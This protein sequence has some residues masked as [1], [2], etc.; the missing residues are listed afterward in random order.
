MYVFPSQW[1]N[2][3]INIKKKKVGNRGVPT[4][5]Q[6]DRWCLGS[7]GTTWQ[8]RSP[9]WHRR[10]K[11]RGCHSFSLGC[12]WGSDHP[13]PGN[14]MCWGGVAKKKTKN[15]C[16]LSSPPWKLWLRGQLSRGRR[17]GSGGGSLLLLC[18][19]DRDPP[20]GGDP[21]PPLQSAL[22]GA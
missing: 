16:P 17:K 21:L 11:T 20:A 19:Q 5:V 3:K 4:V 12:D 9:A 10:L 13:W 7:A 1:I 14:S 15:K 18:D 22:G 8:V 6:W 2:L